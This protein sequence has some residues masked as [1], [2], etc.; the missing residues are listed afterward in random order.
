MDEYV[1]CANCAHHFTV[2][3]GEIADSVSCPDCGTPEAFRTQ[4]SP[5]NS[6]GSMRDMVD[7][8]S[9]KDQGGNPLG[10]GSIM[11][12]SAEQ[13]AWRRDNF[14]HGAI[15]ALAAGWFGDDPIEQGHLRC[16]SCG[17]EVM[18]DPNYGDIL[19]TH[20]HNSWPVHGEEDPAI[21]KGW[22]KVPNA[23]ENGWGMVEAPGNLGPKRQGKTADRMQDILGI[24]TGPQHGFIRWTPGH[25]GRGLIIN[26][27]PHTWSAYDP[28]TLSETNDHGMMH[29]EYL[30]SLGIHPAL[31]DLGS[32]IEIRPTGEIE[33]NPGRDPA[34]YLAADPR[35]KPLKGNLFE[36]LFELPMTP[37]ISRTRNMEPYDS[38]QHESEV[39]FEKGPDQNVSTPEH[40]IVV[41]PSELG[42]HN[43]HVKWLK[44][45]NAHVN[46]IPARGNASELS[47]RYGLRESAE[48]GSP[49]VIGV[50]HPAYLAPIAQQLQSPRGE[51]TP[52]M[53]E[54]GRKIQSGEVPPPPET[55]MHAIKPEQQVAARTA[56]AAL[57]LLGGEGLMGGIA[58]RLMGGALFGIGKNAIGEPGG[59]QGGGGQ[60]PP[61]EEYASPLSPVAAFMLADYES[62]SSVPDIGVKHDDPEDVDT[63]EFN[64]QDKNPSNPKNPNLEDSGADNEDAV[65]DKAGFGPNSAAIERL[66]L[67]LP[68]V[69]HFYHSDHSGAEDP[70]IKGLH[71]MLE[72]ENPGYLN[73]NSI[74][75]DTFEQLLKAMTKPKGEHVHA[76][77]A[78]MPIQQGFG[79][80]LGGGTGQP[81]GNIMDYI[82]ALQQQQQAGQQVGQT[83]GMP[84]QQ[85]QPGGGMAGHCP[86]CG[87]VLT[88]D[89]SCP[90]CGSK[91]NGMGG[92]TQPGQQP[93]TTPGMP[94]GASMPPNA[95]SFDIL[96][97]L[98]TSADHQGPVTPEQI[99]AVQQWL[100]EH[101]RADQAPNVNLDPGNPEYAKILAEI[102]QNPNVPPTVTPEEQT[103]PPA[104]QPSA[105]GAMPV[106]GMAPG[107]AGG[108]P[109]QPMAR[110]AADNIARR[111][112]KCG[113]ATTG[114][115]NEKSM[116]CHACHNIWD[117]SEMVKDDVLS[118]VALV[119]NDQHEQL[120]PMGVPA[121]E[122]HAPLNHGGD[123]DSSLTWKDSNGEPIKAHQEYEMHDPGFEIP[124][125]IR[126]EAVQPDGLQVTL[127]GEYQNSLTQQTNIS[128]EEMETHQLEFRPL[129][130]GTEREEPPVGTAP[131]H[132]H[133]PPSGQTTDEENSLPV[134]A[135]VDDDSCPKCGHNESREEMSAPDTLMHECFRCSKVWETKEAM[136][137][138]DV[139]SAQRDWVMENSGPGSDDFFEEYERR[140]MGVGGMQSRD[141]SSIAKTDT[142]SQAVS[143]YLA[144][145]KQVREAGK[146]FNHNEQRTLIDEDGT[147]RNS[148]LL[149]LEGTHYHLRDS[150]NSKANPDNVPDSHFALGM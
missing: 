3:P 136:V 76:K 122:Q 69:L 119:P 43:K 64:D 72:T 83:P 27:E 82:N 53:A 20:C 22:Q 116:H 2:A 113:S 54:L 120:N 91:T 93:Y 49:M 16:P 107:E 57:A 147:A 99:A 55:D 78:F 15:E 114:I 52:L 19:C 77:T 51:L 118:R 56:G 40:S 34:P 109:M 41:N 85:Q 42:L 87:G 129:G 81:G 24:D 121:S 65:E 28:A 58:G 44:F 144:K 25:H 96:A 63:K 150:Y 32:G 17:H 100:I 21:M 4:P 36:Q 45:L 1:Q 6:D 59:G 75:D 18:S 101:G 67:L 37:K 8:I 112:P 138:I 94:G 62:P 146:K 126:V 145:Q 33:P 46:G 127:L 80:G 98:M 29:G 123:E 95:A 48:F 143:E 134:H 23:M 13:P 141:L 35:L 66:G 111:C 5:T 10:E 137:G 60:P 31:A 61:Q 38:W 11:Y 68:L 92:T 149:D 106:P 108:Q 50:H 139:N 73:D 7:P 142:R 103:Q 125:L 86:S 30:K 47:K 130:P 131:G 133:M 128:K 9:Q 105:P 74:D 102:Q 70:M 12:P 117:T 79:Q 140:R 39:M 97:A 26:G 148:D 115:L 124:D 110:A 104:P 90:Q 84:Q 89:G 14:M 88:A 71:E 132:E 135:S